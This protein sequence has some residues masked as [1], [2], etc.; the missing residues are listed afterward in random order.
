MHVQI[1]KM[2]GETL[3]YKFKKKSVKIGRSKSCE[4]ILVEDGIS[5][6][7][8][9]IDVEFDQIY[10][11]D[12]EST[13][14]VMLNDERIPNKA[15]VLYMDIFDVELPSGSKVR[16]LL[17]D[18][19]GKLEKPSLN[20]TVSNKVG[21]VESKKK[22]RVKASNKR[23]PKEEKKSSL[24]T[25]ILFLIVVGGGYYLYTDMEKPSNP[26]KI[27]E[28]KVNN[29]SQTKKQNLAP[30]KPKKEY[31]VDL[32][33]IVAGGLCD[34]KVL[35]ICS[36]FNVGAFEGEGA[37]FQRGILYIFVNTTERL[38]SDFKDLSYANLKSLS[39]NKRNYAIAGNISFNPLI[40][41]E[42][43]KLG[44]STIRVY[45]FSTDEGTV[46]F[47]N[48]IIVNLR[49]KYKYNQKDFE[50]VMSYY[51]L[52]GKDV[53]FKKYF[54]KHAKLVDFNL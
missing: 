10:L 47:Q 1:E 28:I 26:T 37:A 34:D 9:Q 16:V 35:S 4:I 2:N 39:L 38:N 32:R 36:K 11:I 52:D 41:S 50:K 12:L 42:A 8:L 29:K 51:L 33:K 3:D 23:Q 14:G 7:H 48:G 21:G 15:K 25:I 43:K 45:T 24:S 20:S 17:D 22:T 44:A 5:R 49:R 13:N 18:D 30:F 40:M 54:S 31:R 46:D 27:V 53:F 6:E 19:N